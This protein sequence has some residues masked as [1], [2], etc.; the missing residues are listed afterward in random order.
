MLKSSRFD[1]MLSFEYSSN[2]HRP[3]SNQ[4]IDIVAISIFERKSW[5]RVFHPKITIHSRTTEARKKLRSS[6]D[7]LAAY[8]KSHFCLQFHIPIVF[9]GLKIHNYS[10]IH[11]GIWYFNAFGL[12]RWKFRKL[13]GECRLCCTPN[14]T[15]INLDCYHEH[16][17]Q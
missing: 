3:A 17:Q 8:W 10:Q 15:I 13:C 16:I 4:F 12:I 2:S 14:H 5:L 6:R 1:C 11:I 7:V 9:G